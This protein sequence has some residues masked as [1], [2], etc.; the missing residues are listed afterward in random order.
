MSLSNNII[1]SLKAVSNVPVF[2]GQRESMAQDSILISSVKLN[3]MLSMYKELYAFTY[4]AWRNLPEPPDCEHTFVLM[5]MVA[6]EEYDVNHFTIKWPESSSNTFVHMWSIIDRLRT[7]LESN[8][9]DWLMGARSP[10]GYCQSMNMPGAID[11]HLYPSEA[12]IPP[13]IRV[14][15][16]NMDR[17]EPKKMTQDH[18]SNFSFIMSLTMSRPKVVIDPNQMA[19]RN[20]EAVSRVKGKNRESEQNSD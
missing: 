8:S 2:V 7:V 18:S 11:Q 12:V 14:F 6:A 10:V 19:M 20:D 16:E 9:A 1:S 15:T 5:W 4:S 13:H 17:M 3:E